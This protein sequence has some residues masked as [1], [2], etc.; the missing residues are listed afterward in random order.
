MKL[1]A[2]EFLREL[3]KDGSMSVSD[4]TARTTERGIKWRTLRRASDELNV[5]KRPS[6]DLKWHWALPSNGL[7]MLAKSV[8]ATNDAKP[9]GTA[10]SWRAFVA[11][12]N[13]KVVPMGGNKL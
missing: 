5:V 10:E 9:K 2:I 8:P 1:E 3:L 7:S 4:I 11:S 6:V 13:A 12:H